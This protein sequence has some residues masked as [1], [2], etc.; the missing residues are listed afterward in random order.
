MSPHPVIKLFLRS[1][2][3]YKHF[4]A[5]KIIRINIY[6]FKGHLKICELIRGKVKEKNPKNFKGETPQELAVRYVNQLFSKSQKPNDIKP[7]LNNSDIE[8]VSEKPKMGKGIGLMRPIKLSDDLAELVGKKEATRQECLKS[9]W[10]HIKQNNLQ[11]PEDGRYFTPDEK[12][13]KVFGK[14]R[15]SGFSMA[16]ILSPK[17]GHVDPFS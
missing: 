12:M 14:Q 15:I 9:F 17:L 1:A 7:L 10:A 13:A 4:H 16:K 3:F 8:S 5:L 6:P 11:D 2:N